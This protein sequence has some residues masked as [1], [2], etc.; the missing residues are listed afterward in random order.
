V[1][2]VIEDKST[3]DYEG[4]YKGYSLQFE[5]KSTQSNSSWALKHIHEHQVEHL[6]LSVS[7]GAICFV[8]LE[9][10]RCE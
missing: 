5:A 1:S 3:V 2:A 4:C 8:V 7:M 9:F 10:A 6:R